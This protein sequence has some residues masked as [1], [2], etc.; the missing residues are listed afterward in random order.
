VWL[1]SLDTNKVWTIVTYSPKTKQVDDYYQ[2]NY[3]L[4]DLPE[5]FYEISTFYYGKLIKSIIKISPGA[6]NYVVFNGSAGFSQTL[7]SAPDP[8]QFIR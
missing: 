7:P 2:E 4:A 8:S 6:V 1:T 5:G 3:T